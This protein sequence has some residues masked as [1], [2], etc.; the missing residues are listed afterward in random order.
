MWRDVIAFLL[1]LG[2]GILLHLVIKPVGAVIEQRLKDRYRPK[3]DLIIS[4]VAC[5]GKPVK[6]SEESS[7]TVWELSYRLKL[8]NKGNDIAKNCRVRCVMRDPSMLPSLTVPSETGYPYIHWVRIPDT[9]TLDIAAG[10]YEDILIDG[11][12]LGLGWAFAEVE[13]GTFTPFWKGL[14][15]ESMELELRVG[16]ENMDKVAVSVF[17][18]T[19]GATGV[20]LEPKR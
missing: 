7:R 17:K 14:R 12:G 19:I 16:A 18:F 4:F 1:G 11:Q 10:D 8:E 15:G 6:V 2:T 5:H 20:E 13:N 9:E 3:P